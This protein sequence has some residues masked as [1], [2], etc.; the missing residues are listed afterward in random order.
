MSPPKLHIALLHH[1]VKN[2]HGDTIA[3][4]VTN[5]DLHDI[6]RI[7]RTYGIAA[8]Y[9]VT[10]L[11]DQKTLVGKIVSHWV[12]GWGGVHNPDRRE[13]LTLVKVKDSL[14]QV[15]DEIRTETHAPVQVV[16]TCAASRQQA[17]GFDDF[18][19]RLQDSANAYL[20]VF[21]TAW[22]LTDE[23]I[24]GADHI[25]AP[26]KGDG[27]GYN[28]LPVRAAVAITLDRILGVA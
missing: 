27:S 8:F 20:L 3:S 9:V 28:H 24:G 10:P 26:I 15:V 21:G 12:D 1:P 13:A 2:K 4:A 17:L 25:L 23:V 22:G 5:L 19:C 7:G 16:V 18:K 11:E 14:A 6:A